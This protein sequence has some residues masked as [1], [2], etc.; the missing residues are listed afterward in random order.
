MGRFLRETLAAEATGVR[1]LPRVSTFVPHCV[2]ESAGAV[3]AE[4][5]S[6][7]P[8]PGRRKHALV[9]V[10]TDSLLRTTTY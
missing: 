2:L 4:P 8:H 1:L 9:D 10:G 6:E 7:H 5:A 3:V